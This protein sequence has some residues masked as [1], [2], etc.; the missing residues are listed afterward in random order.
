MSAV[1]T[2]LQSIQG[3]LALQ[4]QVGRPSAP[5]CSAIA[6]MKD[7]CELQT[8]QQVDWRRGAGGSGA[9]T[10]SPRMNGGGRPAFRSMHERGGSSASLSSMGN[11]TPTPISMNRVSSR[12]SLTGGSPT[13]PSN[14]GTPTGTGTPFTPNGVTGG[15]VRYQSKLR[16]SSAAVEDKILNNI[17]LSKLNKFSGSTYN[18]IREFLYQI[19]GSGEPDLVEMIRHFMLLVFKKAACE[20]T[21]CPLYAKL[22]AEISDRY[23]VIL[24]EMHK[25][26]A[27]YLHIFDDVEE[28]P[29]GGVDYDSFVAKNKEKQ[30]RQGYSQFM[31]E[32]ATLEILDRSNL[33]QTFRKLFELLERYGTIPDKKALLE[34]YTDCLVR[35]ARVLAKK[36][37][38]F[39][40]EARAAV[41]QISAGPLERLISQKEKY[42]S[43]S[44]KARFILMDVKDYLKDD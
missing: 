36:S 38:P 11:G 7:L 29:E 19:L 26:Q 42:P 34:D 3:L 44:V 41:W 22:L 25:L 30:Y 23:K 33:E 1:T 17:I 21:Y 15:P 10:A 14:S 13:S 5:I 27:N 43:L 8:A 2:P 20:E 37:S 35:M 40:R 28:P 6:G 9:G 16:N 4:G 18:D 24:E 31:A 39:F 32:L 12:G